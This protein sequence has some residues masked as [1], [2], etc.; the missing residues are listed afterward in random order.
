[1][2]KSL[3]DWHFSLV[4]KKLTYTKC[5]SFQTY[6][7]IDVNVTSFTTVYIIFLYWFLMNFERYLIFLL[8]S[9]TCLHL[10]INGS[11]LGLSRTF[12][13]ISTSYDKLCINCRNEIVCW[14]TWDTC[15]VITNKWV[16]VSSIY[17]VFKFSN[18][19]FLKCH[20]KPNNER[21]RRTKLMSLSLLLILVHHT[22]NFKN[23]S[24]TYV[25]KM[26]C[27]EQW[28]TWEE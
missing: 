1:V 6:Q 8:H 15:F 11:R 21:K 23:S 4:Q 17:Y 22:T 13:Y 27:E 7:Q 25:Q 24:P 14:A 10:P 2:K 9:I 3:H 20:Y 5:Y 19:E 18:S 16:V 28:I 12:S 26:R